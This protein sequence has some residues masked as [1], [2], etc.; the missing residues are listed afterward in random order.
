MTA[1]DERTLVECIK[2][3]NQ[4]FLPLELIDTALSFRIG[5]AF[6]PILD[7][8]SSFYASDLMKDH[9]YDLIP[10]ILFLLGYT[11][12]QLLKN[13]FSSMSPNFQT[14]FI[15][16]L[17]TVTE[18]M[19]SRLTPEITVLNG[20]F[21]QLT[22]RV[23]QFLFINLN[24]FQDC[25]SSVIKLIS[26]FFS[27][28]QIPRNFPKIFD[29]VSRLIKIYPCQRL[30]IQN[31]LEAMTRKQ[32]I[33]RCF[34]TSLI[35]LFFKADFDERKTVTVSSVEVIDA[36]TTLLLHSPTEQI[37][38]YKQMIVRIQTLSPY[39]KSE[40]FAAKL[41]ERMVAQYKIA[42]VIEKLRLAA[43]PPD[44]RA[45]YVMQ[46]ANQHRTFPSMRMKWLKEIV[47]INVN[48]NN[49]VSAFIAQLHIC[50]LIA[51]VFIHEDVLNTYSAQNNSNAPLAYQKSLTSRDVSNSQTANNKEADSNFNLTICQPI[52]NARTKGGRGKYML[53]E[54]DFSFNTGVLVE[55]EIDFESISSDFQFISSDFTI[56]LLKQSIEEAIEFGE[57]S[58]LFYDL[59][60]LYSLQMR[61]FATER[62]YEELA[63]ISK[64]LSNSFH[65]L[66]ATTSQTHD[67][68]LSFFNVN[69]KR[70]YC[71]GSSMESDFSS[72]LSPDDVIVPVTKFE[73]TPKFTEHL[74]CWNRF[75]GIVTKEDL[76]KVTN[77]NAPEIQLV[78]Y[79]TKE[80]LPRF[81]RFSEIAE[82]K[83]VNISL[84]DHAEIETDKLHR[85]IYQASIEF[86]KCFPCRQINDRLVD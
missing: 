35:L 8:I 55:T 32:S 21:N 58:H 3:L 64:G 28:Y 34:A 4:L 86:E 18:S 54:K 2:F 23:I 29:I 7:I 17:S 69:N 19:I 52:R 66:T 65:N 26:L 16:F 46:I 68:Y 57:K 20:L 62:N 10:T 48:C 22:Q 76:E 13:F 24:Y 43:H 56:E 44:E 27:P 49:F 71:V 85:M 75:R 81:T 59:R 39:F 37:S 50:A 84:C 31:L 41:N 9:H 73:P 51:T 45:V 72:S 77:P 82:I 30:L 14:L 63:K 33:A 25:L 5:F 47:R 1:G 15:E 83:K 38:I 80:E 60:C 42:E 6:F 70:V 40:L 61:I 53:N 67:T 12:S 74:H 36:L 78:Q 11:P 79:T